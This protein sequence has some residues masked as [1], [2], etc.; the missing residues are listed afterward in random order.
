MATKQWAS[1]ASKFLEVPETLR[2]SVKA[3]RAEY[4]QLGT[5]GLRVSNPIFGGLQVGSSQWFPWVLD[6]DKAKPLLK[7]AYDRGINTWDTANIYSNGLSERIMGKTIREYNIPRRKVVLMTKCYRVVCDEENYD[8]GSG[9]AML[10]GY[11]EQSKDYVNAWG[12]SRGA[13]FNA[14]EASLE[15]LGTPYIDLLQIHRF[16][17]NVPPEETMQALHDLVKMG[18]VRYLGA[19]SMWAYQFAILQH[20]AE[21]YGLTKFVS[22]Q[23]HYNLLY[24]EEEREMVKF[25]NRS[26][27]GMVPWAPLASGQLARPLSSNGSTLR[28]RVNKNGAFYY[29]EK[30]TDSQVII[31]RVQEIAEKRGWPMS[32]VTLAWLNRR[33]TSPIIGFSSVERIDDALAARGKLLTPEEE[34]YLEEP[35]RPKSIQGHC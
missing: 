6:E 20:A 19:S 5:S 34:A 15:R 29:D 31:S 11:A 23:N 1:K 4:R 26:G 7:A 17:E 16:D 9:I 2:T 21:K 22:M 27:V 25:C 13:I 3:S 33:V 12:L 24:R 18:K 32:H 10:G 30:N 28:S 14:V 8:P 35:Y